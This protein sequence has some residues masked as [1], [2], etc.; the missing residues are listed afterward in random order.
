MLRGDRPLAI[1]FATVGRLFTT[2]W[3]FARYITLGILRKL[4]GQRDIGPA[5]V[6]SAFEDLGPTYLKFGQIIASSH[7]MFP[8]AYCKEFQKMLDRVQAVRLRRRRAHARASSCARAP[9]SCFD[10]LDA[11]P[12]ASASIAQVHAARLPDGRESSSRSSARTSSAASPPT[13]A[14]CASSRR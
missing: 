5:L 9:T 12:L 4:R 10:E 7:G 2:G 14:S 8:D 3:V 6:R 1:A 13:C 11:E